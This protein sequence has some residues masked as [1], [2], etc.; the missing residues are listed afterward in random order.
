MKP[1]DLVRIKL[2][3]A[4]GLY[5]VIERTDS[6]EAESLSSDRCWTLYGNWYG[7]MRTLEMFEKW[8]EVIS[9]S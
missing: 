6:I 3:S 7:E 4:V 9:E 2:P 5:I 8:I 1:G